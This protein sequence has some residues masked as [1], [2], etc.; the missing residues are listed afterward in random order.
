MA[1]AGWDDSMSVHVDV[2]DQQHKQLF[3]MVDQLE[4]A[5]SRGE[6]NLVLGQIVEGLIEYADVHF[7]AEERYF[8]ASAYPDCAAHKQQHRDFVAKVTD[9]K[10][11]FEEDRLMLTLDIL[12]FLGDWLVGHIRASDASYAPFLEAAS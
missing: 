9:F 1:K 11:G 7:A 2:I 6:G 4:E 3:A 12:D 8:E 10:R 5:M